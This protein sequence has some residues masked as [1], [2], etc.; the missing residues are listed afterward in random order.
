MERKAAA[1]AMAMWQRLV[2]KRL[3]GVLGLIL[4]LLML[5]LLLILLESGA[6]LTPFVY[7][8]F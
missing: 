2:D 4:G 5:S 6:T 8:M 1:R 3:V 7:S